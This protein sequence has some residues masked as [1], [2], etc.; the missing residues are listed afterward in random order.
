MKW[1][2]SGIVLAQAEPTPM[3]QLIGTFGP[4]ALL[5]VIMYLVLIRPQQKRAKE[6]QNLVSRLKAGDAVVTN[7]GLHG[8][9]KAVQEQT[10]TVTIAEGVDVT[11]NRNAIAQIIQEQQEQ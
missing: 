4:I 10:V 5:I 3:Q 11:V 7:A 6:H 1:L 2:N 9:I 8:K